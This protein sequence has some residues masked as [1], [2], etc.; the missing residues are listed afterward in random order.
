MMVDEGQEFEGKVCAGGGVLHGEIV[1]SEALERELWRRREDRRDAEIAR[2]LSEEDAAVVPLV[3]CLARLAA[4][5]D[6]RDRYARAP[7]SRPV[8]D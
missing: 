3:L 7:K 5:R 2:D 6:V 1:P 4:H 8:E